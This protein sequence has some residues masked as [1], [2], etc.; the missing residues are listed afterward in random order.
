MLQG[1]GIGA[2]REGK[3]AAQWASVLP[4]SGPTPFRT[5]PQGGYGSEGRE[6]LESQLTLKV[7][8]RCPRRRIYATNAGVSGCAFCRG[9]RRQRAPSSPAGDAGT[10]VGWLRGQRS[11]TVLVPIRPVRPRVVTSNV[12]T[13]RS[14]A[15]LIRPPLLVVLG[16]P[17]VASDDTEQISHGPLTFKDRMALPLDICPLSIHPRIPLAPAGQRSAGTAKDFNDAR[18]LVLATR[19]NS[20]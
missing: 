1:F 5:P 11:V 2:G 9:E 4:S 10:R 14:S 6:K 16:L 17:V 18:N 8:S 7:Q 20:Q 3:E 19:T 13:P 15:N 12:I